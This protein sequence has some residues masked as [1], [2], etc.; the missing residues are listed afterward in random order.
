M[1]RGED[2]RTKILETDFQQVHK[3]EQVDGILI[4]AAAG[5]PGNISA[6]PSMV[7]HSRSLG[8]PRHFFAIHGTISNAR[9]PKMSLRIGHIV[10]DAVRKEEDCWA[11]ACPAVTHSWFE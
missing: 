4:V 11:F 3:L 9:R 6:P 5:C 10:G 2:V 8:Q 7:E 1:V